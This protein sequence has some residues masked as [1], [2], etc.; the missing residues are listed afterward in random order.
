V[1]EATW[2][3]AGMLLSGCRLVF[4]VGGSTTLYCFHSLHWM[5]V[6]QIFHSLLL[7]RQKNNFRLLYTLTIQCRIKLLN[8]SFTFSEISLSV[9]L[10]FYTKFDYFVTVKLYYSIFYSIKNFT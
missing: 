2:L 1:R 7:S 4:N 6:N 10:Y 9:C 5:E 8:L 3:N